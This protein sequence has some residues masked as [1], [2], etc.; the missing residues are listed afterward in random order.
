MSVI[1]TRGK[2]AAVIGKKD[3]GD[4]LPP[5]QGKHFVA[6]QADFS[7]TPNFE[8]TEN[9]EIRNDIMAAKPVIS[10]E[11]PSGSFSHYLTGSGAVGVE[12][13]Y[14]AM[15][16]S[17][18]GAKRV[19]ATEAVTIAGSTVSYLSVADATLDDYAKGDS[20]LIKDEVNG[21]SMRPI[22]N[23]NLTDKR[24]ELAFDLE[25]APAA[26]VKLGR[27]I[28]YYPTT[29]G[30]PV[31]D[32]W[33]YF[34]EGS[35]NQNVANCR[36]TSMSMTA[37]ANGQINS[38]FA[39]EGTDYRMN[40]DYVATWELQNDR[41]TI[42]VAYGASLADTV[43]LVLEN[44][45]YTSG[46]ELAAELQLKMRALTGPSLSALTVSYATDV[47]KFRFL[48]AS[49]YAFDFADDDS[50]DGM[51]KLLG[52][53]EDRRTATATA[54]GGLVSKNAAKPSTL[55]YKTYL[56]LQ[57]TYDGQP[58]VI[59]KDQR[60]FLGANDNNV[61]L[62]A[63]SVSVTINTP[64]TTI[65][66]VCATNAIFAKL[67]TS[68]DAT[69]SVSAILQ[70]DDQRFFAQFKNGDTVPFAFMGGQK[71][72]G[73]WVEGNIFT[74]YGSEAS[75]NS[76]SLAESDGVYTLDMELLCFSPGDGT[77]SIFLSYL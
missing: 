31:F 77:G 47:R 17:C 66:S 70:D 9:L 52:F 54:T 28:T 62:D 60:L 49:G 44:K 15:V 55:N 12:T 11:N 25:E 65:Y 2:V 14:A 26:G 32:V 21:W 35:G 18:F 59:A 56:P 22:K 27:Y 41:N 40:Q 76:F 50:D 45:I 33:E 19:V 72:N 42:V 61:C 67:L 63:T 13:E 1:P 24:L 36:T 20:V 29:S 51:A 75:I 43:S 6:L 64:T 23:R 74:V 68:R 5:S 8:T 3:E 53:E 16:E 69:L 10:G 71:Q 4:L 34:S 37:D 46:T 48:N 73:R 30:Q 39:F 58:P 57:P 7:V 38:T